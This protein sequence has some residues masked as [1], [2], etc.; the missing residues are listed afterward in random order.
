MGDARYEAIH[1]DD[2]P[3]P[4]FDKDPEDPD[5]RPLR[6]HFGIKAFGANAYTTR[7][8]GRLVEEH[9]ETKDS[10]SQHEEIYFVAKGHATFTVEGEDVDAPEGTFVYIRDPGLTRSAV[11]READTTVLAFGGTPGE[12]FAVSAWESK[13]DPS[14][15]R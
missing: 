13:Y 10:G 15:P 3:E 5:W 11:A 2:I 12:A 7:R 4:E 1:I 8:P 9:T 6:I 14:T